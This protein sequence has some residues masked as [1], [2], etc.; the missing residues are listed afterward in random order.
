[1]AQLELRSP[2][3]QAQFSHWTIMR[4]KQSVLKHDILTYFDPLGLRCNFDAGWRKAFENTD[5]Q[6]HLVEAR[7]SK[8]LMFEKQKVSKDEKD[9]YSSSHLR[10]ALVPGVQAIFKG[11][12]S[13]VPF[14]RCRHCLAAWI[15]SLVSKLNVR[16]QR[17]LWRVRNRMIPCFH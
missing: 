5:C 4:N 10:W 11:P 9:D 13:E 8:L 15:D 7:L 16:Y 14:A 6:V 1:M 2:L 17:V 12:F 3:H